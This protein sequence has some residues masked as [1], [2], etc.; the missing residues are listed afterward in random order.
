MG[1]TRSNGTVHI[2]SFSTSIDEMKRKD[3][4]SMH[5]VLRVLKEHPRYSIFE[6]TDNDTI[7][8]TM[9]RLQEAGLFERRQ[10][11]P[12]YPWCEATVTEAGLRFLGEA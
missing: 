11:Q 12:A 10:P 3:Q 6:A 2:C 7:A 4:K 1:R 5:A 9:D 8:R